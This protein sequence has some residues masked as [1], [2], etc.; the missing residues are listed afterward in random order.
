MFDLAFL[1]EERRR[2]SPDWVIC[3][4]RKVCRFI[5]AIVNG[6]SPSPKHEAAHNC[7]KGHLGCISGNHL[8][9]DTH[10]GNMAD[11]IKHGTLIYGEDC[12]NVK[13]TDEQ[14]IEIR[15]L[16][17]T[18][19]YYQYQIADMFGVTQVH[20]SDIVNQ[21]K[22]NHVYDPNFKYEGPDLFS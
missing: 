19:R 3:R 1:F 4:N 6:S 22:R 15:R 13:L 14:I 17:K 21:R 11:K 18:G 9:W 16:Y 8:R 2:A 7:G 20:I 10:T 12:W 5:C